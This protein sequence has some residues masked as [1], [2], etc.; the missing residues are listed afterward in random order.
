MLKNARFL[1]PESLTP[2]D[3]GRDMAELVASG[4]DPARKNDI[5]VLNE[6]FYKN[7]AT[8]IMDYNTLLSEG[9]P[10]KA[11]LDS[12]A[13]LEKIADEVEENA[14]L[15]N[16]LPSTPADIPHDRP[17]LTHLLQIAK[18]SPKGLFP[19]TE[20]FNLDNLRHMLYAPGSAEAPGSVYPTQS[21]EELAAK[22]QQ[23]AEM[24]PEQVKD[25][26]VKVD[27]EQADITPETHAENLRAQEEK[28]A[29]AAEFEAAEKARR[30]ESRK[31]EDELEAE[32]EAPGQLEQQKKNRAGGE[33]ERD[34]E[35]RRLGRGKYAPPKKAAGWLFKVAADES[36]V[37]EQVREIMVD[38][39][40]FSAEQR[41]VIFDQKINYMLQQVKDNIDQEIAD[42]AAA[43]A[44][45][46][47]IKEQKQDEALAADERVKQ[48]TADELASLSDETRK[49]LEDARAEQAKFEAEDKA[50]A[51][52][53]SQ[54]RKQFTDMAGGPTAAIPGLNQYTVLLQ[55][56]M[57][58]ESNEPED[59]MLHESLKKYFAE[60]KQ[61]TAADPDNWRAPAM[62]IIQKYPDLM[63]RADVVA[64][65][66]KVQ[67]DQQELR[68]EEKP[69]RGPGK[70]IPPSQR[71]SLNL[72]SAL[73]KKNEEYDKTHGPWELDIEAK[74]LRR[75]KIMVA[76]A[77]MGRPP[78][79]FTLGDMV[80][81]SRS[82]SVTS[83]KILAIAAT[84]YILETD[85]GVV[86]VSH[87]AVFE[88]AATDLF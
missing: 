65:L 71:A 81:F 17:G 68:Q 72:R 67:K 12:R 11:I 62:D 50:K 53:Q 70:E 61:A 30:E 32:K 69:S 5:I 9:D 54:R 48:F 73:I 60:L 86:K 63:E 78:V 28:D 2:A 84:D 8:M 40:Y 42:R 35:D 74:A 66:S 88:P 36:A 23:L 43:R 7:L 4:A 45:K 49:K 27:L 34:A 79:P 85:K 76:N 59:Q 6:G 20:T 52:S 83:G 26:G 31:M 64:I 29:A 46:A 41:D 1:S 47:E 21:P 39:G 38:S 77:V 33:A 51:E 44:G 10:N 82:S 56:V 16:Q 24:G 15:S 75:R 19:T 37:L 80:G 22:E 55:K 3:F 57:I 18:E 87:E 13:T 25:L 58:P 14:Q